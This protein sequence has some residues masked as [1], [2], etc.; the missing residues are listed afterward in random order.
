[1]GV[2]VWD[3]IRRL[4]DSLGQDMITFAFL[5]GEATILGVE[6]FERFE[7]YW[8]DIK[9]KSHLQTNAT[10]L[11]DEFCGFLK[12]HGYTVGTSLDGV[13]EVH[14]RARDNSFTESLRGITLA[15]EYGILNKI[16]S[17]ITNDSMPHIEETFE[18]FALIGVSTHFNAGAPN[19][20][21]ANY[22]VAMRKIY[23]MW[24]DFGRPFHGIQL[25]RLERR[26]NNGEWNDAST[27]KRGGCMTNAMQV[28]YNGVVA[29]C[30]QLSGHKEYICGNVLTDH[31]V[32]IML[33]GNRFR[34]WNKTREIRERCKKCPFRFVCSGG[35]YFN[36]VSS[37]LDYDPYC[38]GGA[39]MYRAA[40]DRA[41]MTEEYTEFVRD[42]SGCKGSSNEEGC[43]KPQG[44]IRAPSAA[45]H[46][47][48]PGGSVGDVT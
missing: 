44:Q 15:K 2:D 18:L 28:D 21:P 23:E 32:R 46:H 7:E 19:L 3:G 24:Y 36:A 39:G 6:Y 8:G 31:P 43:L 4:V 34:F 22:H 30:S 25:N 33:S 40:L 41:G 47:T 35:C 20:L 12:G 38:G 42:A 37:N 45:Q 13:P 27:P 26:I 29:M 11:D 1:M 16:L 48:T 10:L 14:N 5:G 17:T 9:H